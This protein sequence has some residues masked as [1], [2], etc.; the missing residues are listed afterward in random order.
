L[1]ELGLV[2]ETQKQY[3]V[4]RYLNEMEL[5][6]IAEFKGVTRQAV[7]DGL[8]RAKRFLREGLNIE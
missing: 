4:L 7:Y 1:L 2:T 5:D 8:K 3:L 6:E